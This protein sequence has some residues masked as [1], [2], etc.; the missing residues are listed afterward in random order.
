M[1]RVTKLVVLTLP[2][3][4]H[5]VVAALGKADLPS[6][7]ELR[8]GLLGDKHME[9]LG[10]VAPLH[11]KHLAIGAGGHSV[12]VGEKGLA[13]LL[14]SPLAK[15]LDTLELCRTTITPRM[16]NAICASTLKRFSATTGEIDEV[17]T[18]LK[19]RFKSNFVVEDEDSFDY[20]LYGTK[21]I[22]R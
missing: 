12:S 16:A 18:Q 21:G 11:L 13:S 6:L 15:Q 14:G 22:S 17:E 1:R 7:R 2:P 5:G 4:Q 9:A 8:I 10:E 3:G 20:L 19:A